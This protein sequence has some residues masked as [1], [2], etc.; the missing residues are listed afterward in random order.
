M[1]KTVTIAVVGLGGY[2]EVYLQGLLEQPEKVDFALIAGIDPKPEN[3]SRLPLLKKL[4]VPIYSSLDSFYAEGGKADLVLLSSPIQLHSVHTCL[5]LEKGSNVLCEKPLAGSI[6]E[7]DV[8][9]KARNRNGK[10]VAI[11]YQWS[12]TDTIQAIKRDVLAGK[13]GAPKRLKTLALWPRD[14]AYYNRNNWAGRQ[15]SG[16]GRWILDS[17]VNNA[18]AHYLH[19]MLFVL[20]DQMTSS[21][22]L[23]SVEAE[24][25]RANPIENYDTAALRVLTDRDVE[26]LFLVSHAVPE[27]I[28]PIKHYEFENATLTFSGLNSH[29]IARFSDGTKKDYGSPDPQQIKK[30]WDCIRAVTSGEEIACGIEAARE[31]TRVMNGA[32]ESMPTIVEFPQNLLSKTGEAGKQL[33]VCAGLAEEMQECYKRYQLPSEREL[34]WAVRGQKID[35]RNYS[36]FPSAQK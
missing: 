7:A 29:F 25:Y 18:V 5:A 32:Q 15:K 9:I 4:G 23:L 27:M 14:F 16:D 30:M 21:A 8:M 33:T 12:F 11:G 19:N 1:K 3:C 2:G 36:H 31:Q 22:R 13:F 17:P 6:Q 20:G 34:G 26:I 24:L 28:G 10:F 35:L